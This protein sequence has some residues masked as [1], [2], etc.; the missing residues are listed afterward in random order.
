MVG[1][2]TSYYPV[3]M[4]SLTTPSVLEWLARNKDAL[5]AAASIVSMLGVVSIAVA[6]WNLVGQQRES[7]RRMAFERT[8]LSLE[9]MSKYYDDSDFD[10]I[11]HLL[12]TR[13][14]GG[15]SPEGRLSNADIRLLNYFEAISIAVNQRVLDVHLVSRMLGTPLRQLA[16]NPFFGPFVADPE[17]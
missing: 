2:Q 12:W 3:P 9:L 1:R 17:H 5:A 10:E 14:G 4:L 11:R 16:E 6:L 8:K 15:R 13:M 7:K